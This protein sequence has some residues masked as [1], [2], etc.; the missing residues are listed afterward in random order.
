MKIRSFILIT[1]IALLALSACS[2]QPTPEYVPEGAERDKIT[3]DTDIFARNLQDGM[4][5]KDFALFSKNF[6]DGMLKATTEDT[7][8]QI[9]SRYESYGPST[10]LELINV[11]IAGDYYAVRYKVTYAKNVVIMRVVVNKADPRQ[12]SGLWFE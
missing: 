5:T 1:L 9:Y 12:V 4:E 7:F 3:A 8:K 6:D 11:Q 2:T 10:S